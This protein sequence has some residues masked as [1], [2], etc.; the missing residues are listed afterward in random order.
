MS[1]A[2]SISYIVKDIVSCLDEQE[3]N[4]LDIIMMRYNLDYLSDLDVFFELIFQKLAPWGVFVSDMTMTSAELKSHSTNAKYFFE[5]NPV[6]LWET[7]TL[8][9]WDTYTIKFFKES[10]NPKWGL[11]PWISTQKYYFSLDT[12]EQFISKHFDTLFVWDW[13]EY[14]TPSEE[15]A[16]TPLKSII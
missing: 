3:N 1:Y 5:D 14:T 2:A 13:R 9:D 11:L 15:Y 10:W 12:I 4:S 7:V 6:P 8:Q 16:E